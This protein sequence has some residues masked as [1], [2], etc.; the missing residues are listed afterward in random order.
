[1]SAK[2]WLPIHACINACPCVLVTDFSNICTCLHVCIHTYIHVY[3]NVCKYM[4]MFIYRPNMHTYMH[5]HYTN[6]NA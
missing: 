2:M 1:M 4:Y 6:L 5:I 3:V